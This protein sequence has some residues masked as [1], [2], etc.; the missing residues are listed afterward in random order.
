MAV[1][2]ESPRVLSPPPPEAYARFTGAV[3]VPPARVNSP[4][5]ITGGE[6]AVVLARVWPAVLPEPGLPPRRLEIG[7]RTRIRRSCHIDTYHR[8]EQ[9]G[10]PIIRQ[11][12]AKPQPV[13]VERRAFLGMRALVLP[14]LSI[15]E[16]ASV[17]AGAVVDRNVPHRTLVA[18]NPAR[19]VRAW[20]SASGTWHAIDGWA[21]LDRPPAG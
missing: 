4:V 5:Y 13:V 2:L 18:G 6:E 12:M 15:G 17:G 9:P 21:D 11:P 8:H 1:R 10:V 7:A 14:G 16:N 20:D 19:P 3:V